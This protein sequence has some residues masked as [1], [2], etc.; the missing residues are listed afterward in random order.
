LNLYPLIRPILFGLDPEQA[1]RLAFSALD[2]C[3]AAHCASLVAG[4]PIADPVRLLGLDFPNRV[5]LAAGADKDAQHLRALSQVGFGFIEAGTVTP[6]GQPGNPKP[7][8]FRLPEAEAIINRLGFN[9]K[10]LES[11]VSAVREARAGNA[12]RGP[13]GQTILGLNLGKNANTPIE[14]ASDDY[15]AGLT[16]SYPLADY[17]TINISSPNTSGLRSLQGADG[18]RPLLARLRDART[19]L[20]QIHRRNVP[21]LVK[22]APDLDAAQIAEMA[23]LLPEFGID[24]VIATNTTIAREAVKHL[25]HGLEAGG[26]SGAPVREASTRVIRLLRTKLPSAMPIIGV[27]GILTGAD[28]VEKIKAGA[29]L[30]Q[31]YR[32]LIYRGPALV[33]ECAQAIRDHFKLA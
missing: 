26:L 16:A 3:T 33:S 19:E 25:G 23:E 24:G 17:V 12:L 14:S 18:L 2:L 13:V 11:F 6:I 8:M 7:R 27:G 31:V 32:G 9:N 21:L 1:H 29:N 15:V 10:G 5:G 28:A 4:P 22:I 30:V 20:C